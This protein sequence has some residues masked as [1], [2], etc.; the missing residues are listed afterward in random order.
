[1]PANHFQESQVK[2]IVSFLF[3]G[4]VDKVVWTSLWYTILTQPM[5]PEKKSLNFIFPT[6]Y[7]IPKSLSRLAIGQVSYSVSLRSKC[8]LRTKKNNLPLP[9]AWASNRVAL[10]IHC[11]EQSRGHDYLDEFL[12]GKRIQKAVELKH[13]MFHGN[14]KELLGDDGG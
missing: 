12:G 4:K 5:D 11:V 6:K 2:S 14:L 10:H 3:K 1:M 8:M 13:H 7:V 9:T